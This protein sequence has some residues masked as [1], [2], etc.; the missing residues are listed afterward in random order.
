MA[1][2]ARKRIR[3]RGIVQG[4]GFR[5]FVH[6]LAV[7]L[8][9]CGYVLN[10]SDGLEIEIEGPPADLDLFLSEF[11]DH[12]PPL[13]EIRGLTIE[14]LEPAG[15]DRFFIRHSVDD[16]EKF[17]SQMSVF[18]SRAPS[19]DRPPAGTPAFAEMPPPQG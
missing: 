15:Y 13:A 1:E 18:A 9:L 17:V 11:R 6:N 12:A 4:V 14:H 16:P 8:H 5:P 7:G 2:R 3:V 10:S 19:W